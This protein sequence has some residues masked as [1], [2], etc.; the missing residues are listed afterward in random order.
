MFLGWSA[1]RDGHQFY[2]RQIADSKWSPDVSVMNAAQLQSFAGLCGQVL[3][4]AHSRS[5]SAGAIAGYLGPSDRFDRT[6]AEFAE[7]YADQVYE[8]YAAFL[9]ALESGRLKA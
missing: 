6:I 3:A 7:S 1:A 8:D 2:V 4:I 5:G 9:R